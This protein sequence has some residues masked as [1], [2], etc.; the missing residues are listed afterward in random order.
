ML[1]QR[2]KMKLV[3]DRN[4]RSNTIYLKFSYGNSTLATSQIRKIYRS[5]V[6]FKLKS[7]C[8]FKYFDNR[9]I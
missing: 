9:I 7:K 5:I 3:F 4:Q 1:N 2:L 8:P 6:I